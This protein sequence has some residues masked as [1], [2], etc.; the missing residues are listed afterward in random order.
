MAVLR[1]FVH[2]VSGGLFPFCAHLKLYGIEA[3]EE[4][5]MLD[6]SVWHSCLTQTFTC[7]SEAHKWILSASSVCMSDLLQTWLSFCLLDMK[8]SSCVVEL[9]TDYRCTPTDASSSISI[10]LLLFMGDGWIISTTMV[11][12][13]WF[14]TFFI[15]P[16]IGNNHPRG[17]NHQPDI[18]TI[19]GDYSGCIT[20]GLF[21]QKWWDGLFRLF[22]V[23]VFFTKKKVMH[24]LDPLWIHRI[25]G[26]GRPHDAAW[27]WGNVGV[28]TEHMGDGWW[29]ISRCINLMIQLHQDLCLWR[30][31][32][33]EYMAWMV[34]F[35]SFV[36]QTKGIE[37]VIHPTAK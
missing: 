34:I 37:L 15:F 32:T 24:W 10:G 8:T 14:E 9:K 1:A 36:G 26:S 5:P 11:A 3:S 16:Y 33:Q 6:R 4:T 13:C 22:T 19:G 18:F 25:Y 35:N 20:V 7:L 17:S 31:Q 23:P 2:S 12:G 27:A 21:P 30:T 28:L 29:C